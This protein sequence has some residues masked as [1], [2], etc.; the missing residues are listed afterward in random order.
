MIF[1]N[2]VATLATLTLVLGLSFSSV[3][4][5]KKTTTD[6]SAENSSSGPTGNELSGDLSDSDSGKAMGLQTVYYAYDSN[7]LDAKSKAVLNENATILK[8]NNSVKIQIEG[9]C[10]ERGGIQYNIALGERRATSAKAFLLDKGI[11]A[12]RITIISYG[13]EKPMDQ[14]HDETSWSKNRRAN[15][16]ITEK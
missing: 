9:H 4:C 12:D 14:G 5:S 16:R 11:P 1:K 3:S 15:F 6:E 13:K 7:A 2:S 10:D 8:N